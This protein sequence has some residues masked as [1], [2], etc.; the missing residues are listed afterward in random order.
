MEIKIVKKT[1]DYFHLKLTWLTQISGSTLWF[2]L[3]YYLIIRSNLCFVRAPKLTWNR[4]EKNIS[5]YFSGFLELPLSLYLV[6]CWNTVQI[7][8]ENRM[9]KIF[10]SSSLQQDIFFGLA[11]LDYLLVTT[12]ICLSVTIHVKKIS[13]L[14]DLVLKPCVTVR[15]ISF[16]SGTLFNQ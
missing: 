2:L 6:I 1:K 16:W 5:L 15:P 9:A 14:C 10:C 3:C 13:S 4:K 8:S 12:T 11:A 7:L